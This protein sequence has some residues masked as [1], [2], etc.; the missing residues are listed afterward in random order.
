MGKVG[1]GETRGGKTDGDGEG[2]KREGRKKTNNV[3]R[4]ENTKNNQA[5]KIAI[6][7]TSMMINKLNRC[8][9]TTKILLAHH[10]MHI[11]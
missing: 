3:R 2:E 7:G 9:K 5:S 4:G 8:K 11:F 1:G 10:F 6:G